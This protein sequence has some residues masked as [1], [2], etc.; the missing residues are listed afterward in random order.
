MA[1]EVGQI[2]TDFG[3]VENP[4]ISALHRHQNGQNPLKIDAFRDPFEALFWFCEALPE[5][6]CFFLVCEG[7]IEPFESFLDMLSI[8]LKSLNYLF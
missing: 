5:P 6:F 7:S 4:W 3:V 8:F 2:L 1:H